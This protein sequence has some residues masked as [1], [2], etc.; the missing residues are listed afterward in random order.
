MKYYIRMNK[1]NPTNKIKEMLKVPFLQMITDQNEFD[2]GLDLVFDFRNE[3]IESETWKAFKKISDWESKTPKEDLTRIFG[4]RPFT[5]FKGEELSGPCWVFSID[6]RVYFFG[7]PVVNE[8]VLLDMIGKWDFDESEDVL[9]SDL[10]LILSK[11]YP[12]S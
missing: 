1:V 3:I 9:L 10:M 2:K 12:E 8:G 5:H 7:I 4:E 6:D 11:L